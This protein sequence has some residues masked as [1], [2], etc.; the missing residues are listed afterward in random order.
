MKDFSHTQQL[1]TEKVDNISWKIVPWEEI[2]CNLVKG[3]TNI[4]IVIFL[5]IAI[6][7]EF[8]FVVGK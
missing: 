2:L 7:L 8:F 3:I 4:M 5:H 1:L 6:L